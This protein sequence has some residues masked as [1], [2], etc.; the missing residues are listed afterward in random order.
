MGDKKAFRTT[1]A[2]AELRQ[3]RDGWYKIQAAVQGQAGPAQ[4]LIY[5]EI[6][7]WG[8]SA[9]MLVDQL[10]EVRG[11]LEVHI[12]SPGGDVF[13]GIAIMN[14]LKQHDG[15][16]T[17]MV[18]GLA[19]SAASVIAMAAA[20]G[21]LVMCP[22]SMLMIHEAWSMA[23]GSASDLRQTADLLDKASDN[24]ADL[25]AARTGKPAAEMRAAMA[26]ESWYKAQ[27]AV[28][29]G[30][31]DR[32]REAADPDPALA[33]ADNSWDLAIFSHAPGVKAAAEQTCADLDH[34][35][36]RD[37]AAAASTTSNHADDMPAWLSGNAKE[38]DR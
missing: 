14:A 11:D 30:L 1:R 33:V 15:Q 17:V 8:I 20:P 22:G 16:V 23:I 13:D 38:A 19:A 37:A 4:L 18:D 21:Q 2:L 3:G 5:D 32:I 29:A 24:I 31:A 27:E 7:W 6:S 36:C 34:Q 10:A 28:D 12:N 9:Q 25:Y 26:A 35:C